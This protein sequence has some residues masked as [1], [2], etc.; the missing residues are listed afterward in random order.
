MHKPM[1]ALAVALAALS[2]P[3]AAELV[4]VEWDSAGQFSKDLPV[5]PGKFVEVCEKLPKAAKVDWSFSAA[6]PLDFNI[7]FHEGKKVRF[8]ARKDQVAKDAG[9]LVTKVSQDYCWMWTNKAAVDV[10]LSIKLAKRSPKHSP[11][12]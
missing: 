4:P 2:E 5:A 6:A 7:H 8:P 11:K 3:A 9:T 10:A 1:I 12:H